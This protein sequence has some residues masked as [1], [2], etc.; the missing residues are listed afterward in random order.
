MTGMCWTS[1]GAICLPACLVLLTKCFRYLQRK[2]NAPTHHRGW[3]LGGSPFWLLEPKEG[4][5]RLSKP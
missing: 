2:D 5:S 3:Q 1:T 4:A